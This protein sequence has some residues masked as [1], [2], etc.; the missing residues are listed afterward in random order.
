MCSSACSKP[1]SIACFHETDNGAG[2]LVRSAI[3]VLE[4][5]KTPLGCVCIVSGRC[6]E[7]CD[8]LASQLESLAS[9]LAPE[10]PNYDRPSVSCNLVVLPPRTPK[11]PKTKITTALFRA[12]ALSLSL[13]LVAHRTQISPSPPPNALILKMRDNTLFVRLLGALLTAHASKV[14]SSP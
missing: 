14:V 13:C 12:R 4:K 1:R 2:G 7:P 11:L 6:T 5:Q 10:N 8:R 9:S 3:L